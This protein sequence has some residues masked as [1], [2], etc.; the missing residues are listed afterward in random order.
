MAVTKLALELPNKSVDEM[1]TIAEEIRRKERRAQRRLR[2]KCPP[3]NSYHHIPCSAALDFARTATP[4]PL[5]PEKVHKLTLPV[6]EHYTKA[7]PLEVARYSSHTP[8]LAN[9]PTTDILGDAG[10]KDLRRRVAQRGIDLSRYRFT[11]TQFQIPPA[12]A[13][14]ESSDENLRRTSSHK[15]RSLS[16]HLVPTDRP[17]WTEQ[18]ECSD[19]TPTSIFSKVGPMLRKSESIWSV[20]HHNKHT[21]GVTPDDDSILNMR[22]GKFGYPWSCVCFS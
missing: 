16:L 18:D 19:P 5:D 12:T 20:R 17:D 2:R 7:L 21:E 10:E 9:A 6:V 22:A 1:T 11:A 15:R 14:E 4:E 13:E 8:G 3:Q